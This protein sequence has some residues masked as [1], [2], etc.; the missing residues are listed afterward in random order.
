MSLKSDSKL[1]SLILRHAPEKAGLVLG[2]GG[3]VEVDDLLNGLQGMNR[4]FSYN[5]LQQVVRENDKKRFT[6]SEDGKQI[7][8]AQGHSVKIVGDLSAIK[9]PA[10]L[11]HGTATRFVDAIKREGLKPMKRQH[12]HLSADIETAIKVGRRHGEPYIF[13]ILSKQMFDAGLKFF[14]ADN[15]VWLTHAVPVD[16]LEFQSEE[17]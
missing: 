12:V 3:W 6:L 10:T 14:R 16:F 5:R 13:K 11:F 1:L 2:K 9:P 15:G 17:H 4:P 7:R 8:A